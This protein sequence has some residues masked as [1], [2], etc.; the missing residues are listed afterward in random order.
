MFIRR[1]H[2]REILIPSTVRAI[3]DSA[4]KNCSN[5]TSVVFCDEIEQFVGGDSMHNWWNHGIHEKSLSTYCFLVKCNIPKRC[6][7]L[8]IR[9]W[10]NS[11]HRM[12]GRIPLIV[13]EETDSYFNSIDSK[14]TEYEQYLEDDAPMLLELAIWKSQIKDPLSEI[15]ADLKMQCR[16]DSLWMVTII[17]RNVLSHL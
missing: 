2:M 3:D 9:E 4:F 1:V 12:L 5:L 7:L 8:P 11:I 14:L 6:N 15:T 13:S 17:V 10:Q 16:I